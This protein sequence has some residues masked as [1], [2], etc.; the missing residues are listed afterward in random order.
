VNLASRL[1]GKTKTYGAPIILGARTA[2]K[3]NGRFAALQIDLITVKG[4]QEPES[5]YALVGD[6]T[7]AASE[8]FKAITGLTA[9]MLACYR[10]RDWGGAESALQRAKQAEDTFG[11]AGVF[12]LYQSRIESFR[13]DP[14]PPSWDGVFAFD[15]K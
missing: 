7:V 12:E 4:K 10:N 5:I 2:E 14:P 11:L 13:I 15:T 8:S 3:V 6:D 9:E 1:E